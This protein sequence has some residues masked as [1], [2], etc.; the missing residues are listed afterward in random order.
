MGYVVVRG[1]TP[2]MIVIFTL[3]ESDNCD[4]LRKLIIFVRLFGLVA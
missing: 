4:G 3:W 2:V 1:F